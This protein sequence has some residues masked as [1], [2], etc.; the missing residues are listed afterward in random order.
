MPAISCRDWDEACDWFLNDENLGRLLQS[1]LE[2]NDVEH[3]AIMRRIY[4]DALSGKEPLSIFL[5]KYI[6]LIR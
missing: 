4:S 6:A 1:A 3:K 5:E 2:H